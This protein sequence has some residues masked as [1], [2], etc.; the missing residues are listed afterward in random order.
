[1]RYEIL[2]GHS[3]IA[4]PFSTFTRAFEV[5]RDLHEAGFS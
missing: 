5:C 1:M 2:Y 4:V 3:L